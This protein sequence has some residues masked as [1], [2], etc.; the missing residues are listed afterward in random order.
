[1]EGQALAQDVPP[2]NRRSGLYRENIAVVG[3]DTPEALIMA[4]QEQVL[5]TKSI[6]AGLTIH[7][8]TQGADCTKLPLRQYSYNIF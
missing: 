4:A 1:M 5:S 3:E 8:R 7:D 6:E 2:T